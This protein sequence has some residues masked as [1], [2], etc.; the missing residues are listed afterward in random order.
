MTLGVT[1]II[2]T[3]VSHAATLGYFDEA[4]PY[5]PR[6]TPGAGLTFGLWLANIRPV[7]A[8]SGLA[9]T[10]A[11]VELAGQILLP[12]AT[13]PKED[14][15]L[16]IATAA[17]ALITAYSADVDFGDSGEVDL[18]GVYGDPLQV[19]RMTWVEI[20]GQLYRA[21]MITLPVIVNDAWTQAR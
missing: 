15:D 3:A 19:G 20:G 6:T 2:D 12:D 21:A 14:I 1:A 13:E 18:L 11:R 4:M 17:D 5:E 16:R 9:A 7:A 8:R 10:S